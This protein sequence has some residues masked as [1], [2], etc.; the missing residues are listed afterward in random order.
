MGSDGS[1]QW[2]TGSPLWIMLGFVLLTMAIIHFL[3]KLTR[4]IPAS[5]T[6]IVV[7][8]A[9]IIGLQIPTKT[10]GDIASISGGLPSFHI[11]SIP[12]NLETLMIVFPYSL[13]MAMVG[14]IESLL[15]LA[16]VDEMTETRGRGNKESIA[17]GIANFVCGFFGGMGGVCHDWPEY[18]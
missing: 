2:L 9:V 8:S 12:F 4:A 17:Q 1:L 11:P 5:L 3:P 13:I 15:T 6:A 18:H 10:V 7:V 16:V 14:L